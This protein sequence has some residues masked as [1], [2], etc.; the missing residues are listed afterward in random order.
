[1]LLLDL[2]K[3][4]RKGGIKYTKKC[5]TYSKKVTLSYYFLISCQP[6]RAF[7]NLSEPH[8]NTPSSLKSGNALPF[9]KPVCKKIYIHGNYGKSLV[10]EAACS[11]KAE[12]K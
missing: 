6:S 1:M 9:P 8:T 7:Y 4:E 5:A 11:L 3:I 10:T 2:I 12:S